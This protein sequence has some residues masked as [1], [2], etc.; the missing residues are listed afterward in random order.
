LRTGN[1]WRIALVNRPL[2]TERVHVADRLPEHIR[3]EGQNGVQ[4]LVLGAGPDIAVACQV[5][6][7]LFLGLNKRTSRRIFTYGV[8][9]SYC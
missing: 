9:G 2:G 7:E 5:G 1:R 6:K 8:A 3:V 4:D